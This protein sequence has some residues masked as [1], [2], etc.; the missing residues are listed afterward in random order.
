MVKQ[1]AVRPVREREVEDVY[2]D[3]G[4]GEEGEELAGDVFARPC[5]DGRGD[6]GRAEARGQRAREAVLRVW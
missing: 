5:R 3:E 2:A 1:V 4:D 6:H